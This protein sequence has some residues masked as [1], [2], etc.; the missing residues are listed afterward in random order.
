MSND[1]NSD[2]PVKRILSEA[3]DGLQVPGTD[4]P[5]GGHAARAATPRAGIGGQPRGPRAR[6]DPPP[7]WLFAA[8]AS[9]VVVVVI[10][11]LAYISQARRL[12]TLE[13]E[14]AALHE[15]GDAANVSDKLGAKMQ[16]LNARIE[17]L[18]TR[19]D[20]LNGDE[21]DIKAVKQ[22]ATDQGAKIESLSQRLGE[23]EHG[24]K[25]SRKAGTNQAGVAATAGSGAAGGSS[26]TG[27]WVVN[28]IAVADVASANQFEKRLKDMGVHSRI[29]EVD[30]SGKTLRR[31]VATGFNTQDEA[32]N[33]AATIKEKLSLSQNPWVSRD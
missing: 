21:A 14:V 26:R 25:T 8:V 28:L 15:R 30:I 33:F 27:G 23:L 31:V 5:S 10:A 4:S 11:V 19:I 2:D 12:K 16:R 29:D 7:R 17:A 9:V 6:K 3:D 22:L 1:P 13:S 20:I 18:T 32:K 24:S